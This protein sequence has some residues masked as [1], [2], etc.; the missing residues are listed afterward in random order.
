MSHDRIEPSEEGLLAISIAVVW[1]PHIA[2]DLNSAVCS[3]WNV[4]ESHVTNHFGFCDFIRNT[5]L[6]QRQNM[7]LHYMLD[8]E[9]KY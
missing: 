4:F 9:D 6:F 1:M 5:K 8:Y 7:L 3:S 2:L